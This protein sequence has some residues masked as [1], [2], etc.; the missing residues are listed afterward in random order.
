MGSEFQFNVALSVLNHLGR[1]LYR[2]FTTVLG[3]A[4]SNSWDADANNVHIYID[5]ENNQL[6]IKDDGCGMNPNDFRDKFLHIGYSKRKNGDTHTA[7]NRPFIGNKGIGKLALLSCSKRIHIM[8]KTADTD[9]TGAIIDN[10]KIDTGI[11]DDTTVASHDL[12][13]LD[14]EIFSAYIDEHNQGTII[15]F[16]N[17]NNGINHTVGFFKKI[18]ALYFRFALLDNNFNIFVNDEKVTENDL[19]VL[20]KNTQFLWEINEITD[21]YI[22]KLETAPDLKESDILTLPD[23]SIKGFIASVH[24]PPHI[25]IT[26]LK[27]RVSLDLFVNGRLREK[28]ILKHISKNRVYETYIYGQIHF[29]EMDEGNVIDRFTSSREGV[30]SEDPL[31]KYLLDYLETNVMYKISKDW[32]DW[33]RKHKESGDPENPEGL[34]IT[35]RKAEEFINETFKVY[36]KIEEQENT[37]LD[38]EN[39]IELWL[40]DLSEDAK[41]NFPAYVECFITENLLRKYIEEND[42]DLSREKISINDSGNR[43]LVA[44]IIKQGKDSKEQLKRDGGLSIDI[45]RDDNSGLS[46]LDMAQLA[47]IVDKKKGAGRGGRHPYCVYAK[48]KTYR[49]LRNSV[50]H[51]A[52]LTD[53]A[54]TKL[55]SL[56]QEISYRVR[57]VIMEKDE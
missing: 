21:P 43:D 35:E 2:T 12:D 37:S 32:D 17:I 11:E 48:S 47:E 51:T 27:E 20:V 34:K 30:K 18:I 9:Y 16:E 22:R 15:L 55:L 46:F 6:I 45:R 31:L 39:K 13:M 41:Y 57:N 40:N 53:P 19:S 44:N 50:M 14:K 5:R 33:R 29:D 23:I 56:R 28:N 25:N 52:L 38:A 36:G 3:E 8:T 49:P 1:N 7:K 4:I 24:K 54:K 26:E 10:E 42:I